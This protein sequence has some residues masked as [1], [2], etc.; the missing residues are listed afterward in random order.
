MRSDSCLLQ[1]LVVLAGD[2]LVGPVV[3]E[4]QPMQLAPHLRLE[5]QPHLL[6]GDQLLGDQH[7]AVALPR[8]RRLGERLLVGGLVEDAHLEQTLPRSSA[9]P[10]RFTATG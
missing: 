1:P 9:D 6:L 7:V 5:R 2:E 8:R 3:Q 4:E 10:G